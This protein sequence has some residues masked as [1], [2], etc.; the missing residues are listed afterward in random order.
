[1]K[2][3][4][5]VRV[6]QVTKV[7][8]EGAV[9]VQALRGVTLTIEPGAFTVIAGPSGSGK[10]TLLNLLGALD[11]PTTG[12]VFFE[13]QDLSKLSRRERARL[14]LYKIGFVFQAYNLIPVLTALENVAFVL[15]LQGVPERERRQRALEV[16]EQL[17]IADLAHKRPHE[18]SG[19][20]Q[21]R[22]AVARAVVSQPRLV[23]ADEPTA[24]LDSATGARLLDLMEQL[25]REQ[26][27][28]F[29]FSSHDPQVIE[30][31]R[32]LIWLHDGQIKRDET[33]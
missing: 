30:R 12:R 9:P 3:N 17:G 16:L 26:G 13:G 10:T 4:A 20:Q 14:R 19:G 22:V 33:R 27:V 31:G 15:L 32:R 25:N 11:V 7:Y 8:D 29:V 2:S 1:M 28:T 18:M 24:N 21:Q 6:E 5:I 23:L